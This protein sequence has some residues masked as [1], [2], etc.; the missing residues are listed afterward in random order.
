MKQLVALL[1]FAFSS[2]SYF[3]QNIVVQ[4]KVSPEDLVNLVLANT[5][6]ASVSNISASSGNFGD[7]SLSYGFFDRNG[8]DFPFENGVVLSTGRA[9]SAVG[10]NDSVLSET[11]SGWVG[12][13]DLEDALGVRNTTNA[14]ILEFDFT[15]I[16][17]RISFDYIFASEEYNSPRPCDFSDGFAFLLKRAGV[18]EPFQ[19]LAVV[20]STNIHVKVTTVPPDFPGAFGCPDHV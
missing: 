10:P 7:G 6:C 19:N 16:A 18:D 20:P 14:T 3:S 12:D 5:P 9:S 13:S 4:D 11:A 17:N 8:A 2:Q 1:C 15:P